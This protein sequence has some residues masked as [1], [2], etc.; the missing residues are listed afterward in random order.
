MATA[1]LAPPGRTLATPLV[2]PDVQAA[3]ANTTIRARLKVLRAGRHELARLAPELVAA[4]SPELARTPADTRAVEILPLLA[5]CRFLER[6]AEAILA[7]Q[8]LNR[9]GLPFWLMG[10]SSEVHRVPFGRILVIG[11]ANYPLFLAGVQ[12]L[13]ALAAGNAVTWK[14]GRGG[15][16]VAELFASAM[17]RAGLPEGLLRV[18]GESVEDGQAALRELPGKVFFTGSAHVGRQIMHQ[19][20]ETLT[21][22][23]MEL[24]GS[25][26]VIVLPSADLARAVKALAFGMRLNGSSTCLAPRRVLLVDATPARR[27]SFLTQLRGALAT[28]PPVVVPD[29]VRQQLGSLL[30]SAQQE[31]ATIEGHSTAEKLAPILITEVDIGMQ[32]AQADVFAPVLS[33]IDVSGEAGIHAAQQ[34][35]PFAL[36]ASIFG[37][38]AEARSLASRLNTGSV[39]INDLI[40]PTADPRV[41]FGGRSAS[42]FGVTRGAEGLLEMTAVKVIQT[43]RGKTTLHYDPTTGAHEPLFDG[44]IAGSHARTWRKRLQGWKQLGL[45]GKELSKKN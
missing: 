13:Q 38:E 18:T 4:I 11:P 19:L 12:T 37:D 42:G 26:A 3:W 17:H 44:L 2:S 16:P 41:P 35:C 23:V 15:R 7:P 29:S 40:V 31:G 32:L 27:Q 22:S 20:A 33:I 9:R 8:R 36:G 24:S 39:F 5:A 25:D 45:A 6:N 1:V 34:A 30:D 21:P 14:P 28:V 10:V 43:R